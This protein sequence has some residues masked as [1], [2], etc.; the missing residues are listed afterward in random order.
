MKEEQITLYFNQGKSDKVYKASLEKI[1]KHYVVNF[2]YGRRGTTLKTGTKTQ[3]PLDYEKAKKIYDK[4]VNDKSVKGYIP[5]ENTV[6]Y[7]N[8]SDGNQTGIHCQLLNPITSEEAD[9]LINDPSW[10]AQ[11]KKD[12]KRMLIKKEGKIITAINR[13]GFSTG[14]PESIIKDALS[15]T[16][17]FIIDGEAVGETLFVFDIL[18][19]NSEALNEK[20]YQER[21]QVLKSIP[22]KEAIVSVITA[23]T[24]Q[25]K[26]ELYNKLINE[27]SEGIVFKNKEAVFHPGRPNIGGSQLKLKFYDTASVIVSKINDK[28]SVGIS[29]FENGIIK[30]IGNVTISSNKDIP[31]INDIIE[32][33]YLYAYK[34]GSLYQPVFLNHRTDISAKECTTDQLKYK[35]EKY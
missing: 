29:V 27:N 3:T 12:G 9:R 1:E 8:D 21:L 7:M 5:T 15:I 4:L 13:K 24:K 32:L 6:N 34:N 18:S 25:E 17:N 35:Q 14:A 30:D 10:Y 26:Q 2:A 28:R 20:T 23:K 19:Y 11:E 22:S 16:Q 33:K 31:N